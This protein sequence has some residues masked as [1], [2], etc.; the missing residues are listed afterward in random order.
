MKDKCLLSFAACCVSFCFMTQWCCSGVVMTRFARDTRCAML[1]FKMT[2]LQSMWFYLFKVFEVWS[3]SPNL[4][5]LSDG[6]G[7]W[8]LWFRPSDNPLEAISMS[9]K[10]VK[11]YHCPKS[12]TRNALLQETCM[13]KGIWKYV[14]A[15]IEAWHL[16]H[17]ERFFA[18]TWIVDELLSNKLKSI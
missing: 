4:N 12:L 5:V 9:T 1:L 8:E 11:R 14:C 13:G 3:C 16:E 15:S 18:S 6:K 2:S 10:S 7:Y 17:C